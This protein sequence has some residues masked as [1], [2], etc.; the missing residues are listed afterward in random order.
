MSKWLLVD[1]LNMLYRCFYAIPELKRMDGLP[2]NAL[3][4]WVR[5]LWRLKD[6]EK[7]D[8]IAVFFDLGLP[9]KRITIFPQYKANRKKMPN[10]LSQQIPWAKKICKAYGYPVIEKLGYEA[11]DLIASA[12]LKIIEKNNET[13]IVSADKDFSQII[14]TKIVQILPPSSKGS[15]RIWERLDSVKVQ[16]KFGVQPKY[17]TT[18]LSLIGDIVDNIPGVPGVGKK[19]ATNW[20][21]K[22]GN[23]EK[24]LHNIGYLK[25]IRF[26]NILENLKAQL[27]I[28]LKL[29][30]LQKNIS[31]DSINKEKCQPQEVFLILKT[32]EME[33]ILKK[34]Y[35]RL[36]GYS[37]Y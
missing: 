14:R 23:L 34:A 30:T 36:S 26:Q 31:I 1:G 10:A 29:I 8:Q 15:L 17:I 27:K 24:I 12:A 11:D 19:T 18:Y 25:P 6:L 37:H 2:T 7:T 32:L 5:M 28:N 33:G 21:L 20:I 22:Y 9:K 3:Y 4:G 13:C 35:E 16:L